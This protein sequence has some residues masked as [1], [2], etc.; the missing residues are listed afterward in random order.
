MRPQPNYNPTWDHSRASKNVRLSALKHP[1]VDMSL[2]LTTAPINFTSAKR[3]EDV[4]RN[5]D[6]QR[7]ILVGTIPADRMKTPTNSLRQPP[8]IINIRS[9]GTEGVNYGSALENVDFSQSLVAPGS[10][11]MGGASQNNSLNGDGDARGSPV[12]QIVPSFTE[13]A[14]NR[15][16]GDSIPA[17]DALLQSIVDLEGGQGMTDELRD[18]M[19]GSDGGSKAVQTISGVASGGGSVTGGGSQQSSLAGSATKSVHSTATPHLLI[20]PVVT[21]A[22]LNTHPSPERERERDVSPGKNMFLDRKG[23]LQVKE[24]KELDDKKDLFEIHRNIDV[25]KN[26]GLPLA[27]L[28]EHHSHI[29]EKTATLLPIKHAYLTMNGAKHVLPDKIIASLITVHKNNSQYDPSQSASESVFLGNSSSHLIRDSTIGH[30]NETATHNIPWLPGGSLEAPEHDRSN[31]LLG[32]KE[33]LELQRHIP[34]DANRG[35]LTIRS[36]NAIREAFE[37][38]V[39]RKLQSSPSKGPVQ[40][41]QLPPAQQQQLLQQYQQKQQQNGPA[42]AQGQ[43]ERAGG[44]GRAQRV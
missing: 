19:S 43:Q 38:Y 3:L 12:P 15:L 20:K 39:Q 35:V 41:H 23:K 5:A 27:T 2:S 32:I 1:K 8:L 26:S 14:P 24:L 11:G 31:H 4:I 16:R 9:D 29:V 7:K 37:Q 30:T 17:P 22:P 34:G 44:G 36:Q 6:H 10:L 13:T 18:E 40:F 25:S 21:P 42:L 28:Q 33:K